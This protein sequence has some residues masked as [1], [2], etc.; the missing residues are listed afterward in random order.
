MGMCI[1]GSSP[2]GEG[3]EGGG[4]LGKKKTKIIFLNYYHVLLSNCFYFN[5]I[6]KI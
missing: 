5:N 4:G 1:K 2:V 6:A 3:W